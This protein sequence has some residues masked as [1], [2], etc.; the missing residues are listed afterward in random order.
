MET[1]SALLVLCVGNSPHKGQWR[2]ALMSSLIC[3]WINGWVHNREAGGLRRHRAHY[4]VIV[5]TTHH[6]NDKWRFDVMSTLMYM[7]MNI[8]LSTI[9]IVCLCLFLCMHICIHRHE[10]MHRHTEKYTYI[11]II[12][13]LLIPISQTPSVYGGVWLSIRLMTLILSQ[14]TSHPDD[15]PPSIYR[16]SIIYP[17]VTP[18]NISWTCAL[19]GR[20]SFLDRFGSGTIRSRYQRQFWHHCNNTYGTEIIGQFR[21]LRWHVFI[22]FNFQLA[23]Q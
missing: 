7:S 23:G 15:L 10:H 11:L 12:E 4:D 21:I 18:H 3:A 22:E 5:K 13:K 2:V 14:N 17:I 19:Y 20:V 6:A 8:V 1:F 16:D 9:A